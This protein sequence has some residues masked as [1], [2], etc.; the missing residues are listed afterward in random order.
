MTGCGVGEVTVN[1]LFNVCESNGLLTRNG[2]WVDFANQLLFEEAILN[3]EPD[4]D[5]KEK[6][7]KFP[8]ILLRTKRDVR[9]FTKYD[10]ILRD[11]VMNAIGNWTGYMLS[12]HPSCISITSNLDSTWSKWVNYS[13]ENVKI[14]VPDLE[15]NEHTE[16][17]I[18]LLEYEKSLGDKSLIVNGAP[19]T[20]K[21]YFCRDYL[22][23]AL[24]RRT[25]DSLKWRY[26]T[27]NSHLA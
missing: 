19:G 15:F 27:L 21:T 16:K 8:S 26:Y 14:T 23:W 6:L 7:Q 22:R 24:A 2:F 18:A 12:Y 9:R 4:D 25:K 1:D 3:S 20:G 13:H 5:E 10:E 11:E 17:R